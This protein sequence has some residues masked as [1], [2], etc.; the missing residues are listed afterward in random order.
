MTLPPSYRPA[1]TLVSMCDYKE[2]LDADKLTKKKG[3][4]WFTTSEGSIV[5]C[6]M[7]W[8]LCQHSVS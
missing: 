4:V 5:T 7:L 3:F 2:M 6:L 8:G 1:S